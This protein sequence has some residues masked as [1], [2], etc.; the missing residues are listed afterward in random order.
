MIQSF[1]EVS[2]WYKCHLLSYSFVLYSLNCWHIFCPFSLSLWGTCHLVHHGNSVVAYIWP[3]ACPIGL[4]KMVT[5]QVAMR[6]LTNVT[7]PKPSLLKVRLIRQKT[8]VIKSPVLPP[9]VS[10]WIPSKFTV[11]LFQNGVLQYRLYKSYHEYKN[12]HHM[13]S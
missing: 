11:N 2:H 5:R 4:S 6:N 1:T 9:S 10:T 8:H 12:Q 7:I 13:P 3:V